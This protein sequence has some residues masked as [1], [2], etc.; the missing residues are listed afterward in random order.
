MPELL[1]L[2]KAG[3]GW[4]VAAIIWHLYRNSEAERI[5]YRDMHEKVLLSLPKL[6]EALERIEIEKASN[7]HQKALES[8]TY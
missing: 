5:R 7:S 8:G 3:G 1:E 6:T 2:A 4:A